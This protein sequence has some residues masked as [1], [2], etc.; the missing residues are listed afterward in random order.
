MKLFVAKLNRE[1]TDDH[2]KELFSQYGEVEFARVITDRDTGASKCFGFVTMADASSGRAAMD[3]LNGQEYMR[4]RMV[5]KEAEERQGGNS[6][7]PRPGGDARGPRPGGDQRGPRQSE[8]SSDGARGQRSPG[9][10]P[11]LQSSRASDPAEFSRLDAPAR[12]GARAV[13]KK[14][15]EPKGKGKDIYQD[16]PTRPVKAKRSKPKN[17]DWLDDLDFE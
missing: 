11:G 7:G 16:G 8:G 15:T 4:F 12:A 2:L 14:K 9:A 1:V 17:Q 6:R 10:S 5:V 13:G 3:A